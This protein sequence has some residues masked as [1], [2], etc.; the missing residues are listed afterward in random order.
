MSAHTINI[1]R[2]VNMKKVISIL[3]CVLMLNNLSVAAA[4]ATVPT[5]KSA[6][7][8]LYDLNGNKLVDINGDERLSPASVTKVMTMLLIMEAIDKGNLA[9]EDMVT[10][11]AY[12][13]SMGGTQVYLKENEQMSVHDMLKAITVASAND[14]SVAMAEHIAGSEEAFV[15]MM[16]NR[17]K[18]LGMDGTTF[19]NANG[20]DMNGAVTLTTANDI[21]TMS[22][23]LLKH[24]KIRDYTTIWMDSLRGG[25]FELANTNKMLKNY[26]GCFGIKTGYTGE[27]KYSISVGAERDG[28]GFIAV[29]M[30]AETKEDRTADA[31]SLLN[32]GFANYKKVNIKI[33]EPLEAKVSGGVI[34]TVYGAEIENQY[35]V[36]PLDKAG[37][38]KT[39]VIMKQGIMAP[40]KA[41]D[42]IG[43]VLI[44]SGDEV[45]HQIDIIAKDDI[46]K[47]TYFDIYIRLFKVLFMQM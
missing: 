5:I 45:I 36:V 28:M 16:N 46:K 26:P 11:S 8:V 15:S 22:V 19:V 13:S 1:K 3:L 7:A 47:M 39:E 29:V 32:Y 14:A 42:I 30:K 41:G 44:K 6:A 10:T 9:Y 43:E 31:I 23:E 24:P 35:L 20:L 37:D 25:E 21:A 2:G 18:E 17:A 27:A 38:I 34:D 40:V 33:D 4:G 12:A